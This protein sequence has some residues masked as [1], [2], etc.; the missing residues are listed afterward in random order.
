MITKLLNKKTLKTT[1]AVMFMMLT[2]ITTA[3]QASSGPTD[4]GITTSN[5]ETAAFIET[6]QPQIGSNIITGILSPSSIQDN[7]LLAITSPTMNSDLIA[8]SARPSKTLYVIATGYSSTPDQT[9]SSPFITAN[10]SYVY[11]GLIAANFLRFG[12]ELRI[13]DY[14]G[15]RV[16]TVEDRM[17][18]RYSER[19]DVW[20]PSREQAL[21][22]GMRKIKIEIL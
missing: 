12:T 16:F 18:A 3:A 17:N 8:D 10:G 1:F 6:R 21:Q 4:S 7:S 22:F 19:I 13:P 2:V 9:D 5:P 14:F 11:D 15:D 20:F